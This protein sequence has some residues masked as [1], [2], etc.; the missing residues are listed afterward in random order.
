MRPLTLSPRG[1]SLASIMTALVA[2]STLALQVYIPHT[3]GYFNIGEV[4]LYFSALM[5][6]PLIGGISG[7]LGSAI[8]DLVSGY[9]HY[10]IGTLIIKGVEGV[11]VGLLGGFIRKFSGTLVRGLVVLAALTAS[12]LMFT[13]GS[14]YY[15]GHTEISLGLPYLGYSSLTVF[16]PVT[17]WAL[18]A[19]VLFI[20][21]VYT[22]LKGDVRAM[23][24]GLAS[25]IGGI[26]MV[27][28]YFLYEFY[29]LSFGWAALAE[30][31]FNICQVLVGALLAPIIV[32]G[33]S[34]AI[35]GTPPK[36]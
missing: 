19:S 28:G 30:V 24:Y 6:G 25:L 35:P 29:V 21:L 3:K 11:I 9:A 27:T 16:I 22:T 36:V 7:G 10:A 4:M 23:S 31:P 34:K 32:R 5:F 2:V 13:I 26:E 8:A 20:M 33:I 14:T 17:F 12:T 18:P 1:I 15:S